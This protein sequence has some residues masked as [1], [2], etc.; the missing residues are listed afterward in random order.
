MAA[1]CLEKN[2]QIKRNQILWQTEESVEILEANSIEHTHHFLNQLNSNALI[3]YRA[4]KS[5]I[6]CHNCLKFSFGFCSFIFDDC[7]TLYTQCVNWTEL[8]CSTVWYQSTSG[9]CTTN[10]SRLF[11]RI[12]NNSLMWLS[13]VLLLLPLRSCSL[14]DVFFYISENKNHLTNSK[15]DHQYFPKEQQKTSKQN[16]SISNILQMKYLWIRSI[17]I[18]TL[19]VHPI[20]FPIHKHFAF[21]IVN[22]LIINF[23]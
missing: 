13:I 2:G 19:N 9:V 23:M 12:F 5:Q 20:F 18:R 17:L 7:W 16:H 8:N 15:F 21:A 22:M 14:I 1:I 11:I 3:S 10:V 6:I 4:C